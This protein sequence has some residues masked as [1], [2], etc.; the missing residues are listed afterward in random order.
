MTLQGQALSGL[1]RRAM[2]WPQILAVA[3]CVAVN[4]VDGFDIMSSGFT[5]PGIAKDFALDPVRLGLVLS[6]APGGMVL[7]AIGLSPLAD[8]WGRRRMIPL[9][10]LLV[11]LA[12]AVA[13]L[14]PS[15]GALLVGRLLTG[16][17]VGATMAAINTVAAEQAN[18]KWRDL[19]VTLQA[20]G[21]PVG[22][23]VG[24]LALFVFPTMGWRAIFL[25]GASLSILLTGAVLAWMPESLDFLLDRRPSGALERVNAALRQV[26]MDA[27]ASLPAS[28]PKAGVGAGLRRDWSGRGLS[29]TL[30]CLSFFSLMFT[31]YF[32]TSW[33]P[34][35]LSDYGL[36]ARGAVSGAVL[37]NLGGVVGDLVFAALTLRW[38]ARRLGPPFMIACFASA[39]AFAVAPLTLSTLMPIAFA[40]GFLLY[41]SIAC[42]YAMTP[43]L[44]PTAIRTTGTG[45]A[46]GLGR[47]G[48][49]VG[50]L[51]GGVLIAAGWI[52]PAYLLAMATPLILC[53]LVTAAIAR[54][55]V[56]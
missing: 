15:L 45:L 40:M 30:I 44:F 35:L 12:M 18:D 43:S 20:T 53:A 23:T 50:P 21:F 7:G 24:A 32:L 38:P 52:R 56:S 13:G 51:V 3:L 29:T 16:V 22:G 36:S 6:I 19:C 55:A 54:R 39:A 9:Y 14:A 31:F 37:I 2:T 25:L 17:G 49:T 5:G 11:A 27:L 8:L 4:M 1:H 47:I 42:L 46:L 48:A 28:A 34:K 41:G 33:T 26:G 10:L